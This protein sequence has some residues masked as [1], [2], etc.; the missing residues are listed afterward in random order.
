MDNAR[1]ES[2]GPVVAQ[3]LVVSG[4]GEGWLSRRNSVVP[5]QSF[6]LYKA[7]DRAVVFPQIICIFQ[8]T[9]KVTW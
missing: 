5:M 9:T 6:I 4:I 1:L 8:V 3:D 7:K 2:I